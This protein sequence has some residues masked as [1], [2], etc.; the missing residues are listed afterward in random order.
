MKITLRSKDDRGSFD[1]G[2]LKTCH[3]FSFGDYYDPKHTHFRTLRVI[4]EDWIEK[5]VGFPTHGHENMEII[6]YLLEGELEH[7]DSMGNGSIIRP[8]EFQ[9]MSAGSGVRHSEFNPRKDLNAHLYQMWIFPDQKGLAPR[10]KQIPSPI[11]STSSKSE[12]HVVCAPDSQNPPIGIRQDARLLVA[13]LV[14]NSEAIALPVVAGRNL[15]IQAAKAQTDL[16]LSTG[17]TLTL[18][19]GDAVALS[20]L[21]SGDQVECSTQS[22][23]SEILVFDLA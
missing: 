14:R 9:Y 11:N 20:D 16:K 10:Y 18:Q 17:E 6:T 22:E 23:S 4:N 2:W 19:A 8:G 1:H 13:R 3:S 5:G 12:M 15:W 7:K 21:A